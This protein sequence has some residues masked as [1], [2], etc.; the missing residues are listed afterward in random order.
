MLQTLVVM[1]ATFPDGLLRRLQRYA[2]WYQ[3]A[4]FSFFDIWPVIM[5]SWLRYRTVRNQSFNNIFSRSFSVTH[6]KSFFFSTQAV[7]EWYNISGS[8]VTCCCQHSTA[9]KLPARR[10]MHFLEL[11]RKHTFL[12]HI[13]SACFECQSVDPH[14]FTAPAFSMCIQ[15]HCF[16]STFLV[17]PTLSD[18]RVQNTSYSENVCEQKLFSLTWYSNRLHSFICAST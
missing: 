13:A 18:V 1:R 14:C 15:D 4:T 3:Y 11:C 2:A 9:L 17:S 16:T 10:R 8:L 12:C 5:S 7:S 6:W